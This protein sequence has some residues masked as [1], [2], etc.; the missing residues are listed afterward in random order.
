MHMAFRKFGNRLV[1]TSAATLFA[2]FALAV[3]LRASDE[4][5]KKKPRR[6]TILS[7]PTPRK[8]TRMAAGYSDLI[9]SVTKRFGETRCGFT[10]PLPAERWAESVRE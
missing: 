8:R 5:G 2:A 9:P 4:H 3:F 6:S 10:K 7:E 1:A